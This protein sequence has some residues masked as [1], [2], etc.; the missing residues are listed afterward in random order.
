M[1]YD[2][3]DITGKNTQSKY[4]ASI[5]IVKNSKDLTFERQLLVKAQTLLTVNLKQ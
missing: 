3:T 2:I 5:E 4:K 1:R